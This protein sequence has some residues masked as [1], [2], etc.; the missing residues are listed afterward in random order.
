LVSAQGHDGAG[1]K[2]HKMGPVSLF[3]GLV[4]KDGKYR[5]PL[6]T[7]TKLRGLAVWN[8]YFSIEAFVFYI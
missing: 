5:I 7:I 3:K 6:C 1:T 4:K 8:M 2:G